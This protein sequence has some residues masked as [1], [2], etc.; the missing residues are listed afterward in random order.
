MKKALII[1]LAIAL[2]FSLT[3]C[4]AKGIKSNIKGIDSM[5]YASAGGETTANSADGSRADLATNGSEEQ[6]GGEWPENEYTKLL[7]KPEFTLTAAVTSSNGFTVEFSDA[8]IDDMKAYTKK[9]KAAGFTLDPETE[10]TESPDTA[11]YRYTAGNA[12][13]YTVSIF[14]TADASGIMIEKPKK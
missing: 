4:S 12:D 5:L 14:L 2:V 1:I 9:V 10:E 11:V 7:P 3:A 8:T 13:G 6:F